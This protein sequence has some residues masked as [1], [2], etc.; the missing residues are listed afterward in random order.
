MSDVGFNLR[1]SIDKNHFIFIRFKDGVVQEQ[2]VS[3]VESVGGFLLYLNPFQTKRLARGYFPVDCDISQ[4]GPELCLRFP[5]I[6]ENA[7]ISTKPIF[8]SR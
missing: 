2:A 4:L 1:E 5:G 6:I 3:A 8:F 7:Y